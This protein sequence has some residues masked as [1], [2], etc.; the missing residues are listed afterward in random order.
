MFVYSAVPREVKIHNTAAQIHTRFS[1]FNVPIFCLFR[2]LI[3]AEQ[4][5]VTGRSGATVRL[6]E[7][8]DSPIQCTLTPGTIVEVTEVRGR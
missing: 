3:F 8:L 1:N 5:K 2:P 4:Y 6:G 7:P